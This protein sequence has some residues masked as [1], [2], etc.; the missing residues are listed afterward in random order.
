AGSVVRPGVDRS[1]ERT[2][3]IDRLL[4]NKYLAIPIFLSIM[5]LIFWLTFSVI[6]SYLSDI[7]GEGIDGL[8]E[9]VRRSMESVAVNPTVI[10]LVTD[11]VFSGVGSVLTFIPTIIL[12]FFF[13]SMLEDSGYMSRVAFV[14]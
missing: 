2:L 7:L 1:R 13:L 8:S 5:G 4:T 14:M 11:G 12:L 9:L 3:R 10:S 6:G